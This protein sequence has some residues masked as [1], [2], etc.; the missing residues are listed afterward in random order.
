MVLDLTYKCKLAELR[1]KQLKVEILHD[2][3]RILKKN[4][5][6][7]MVL[8]YVDLICFTFKK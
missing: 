8:K 3:K 2:L 6:F 7:Y 4:F 5:K 1:K